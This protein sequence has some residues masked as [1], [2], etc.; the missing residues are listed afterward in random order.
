MMPSV[1][2]LR[3]SALKEC[4]V[5][6]ACLLAAVAAVAAFGWSRA[7]RVPVT[8]DEPHYLIIAASVLRDLDFDVRNNYEQDAATGEIYGPV[9]PHALMR[10]GAPQHMPG[11]G[12]LLAVPFGVGGVVGAR[13]GLALLLVPTLAIVVYRWS[14]N[15]LRPADALL[16][17]LG[18]MACTPVVFGATQIYPDLAGGVAVFALVGW[19][20][21]SDRRTRPAW[22]VYWLVTGLLCWLHVKYYAPSAVLVA[23][24]AWRLWRDDPRYDAATYAVFAVLCLVGPGLFGAFSIPAFGNMLGGREGGELSTDIPRA[25]ELLLGLHL[26]QVH[27]IFL[28]QPFFL[29]GLVALGWMLRRRHPLALPW[30]V[31]YASLIV[32]NAL[33]QI[34]YGG[35]IAPAGRFGWTAMWLWLVPMGVVARSLGG[36]L[37]PYVRVAVLAAIGYQAMHA[38]AWVPEPQRLFN[39][40]FPPQVWQPSLFPAPVM[41]SLPK[42]GPHAGIGYAPNVVW[43]LA[44]LSLLAAGFLRSPKMKYIPA[45]LVAAS[46]PLML[47]VEDDL[48]RSSR[49]VLRRYEA[50]HFCRTAVPASGHRPRARGCPVLNGPW[51]RLDPGAY[52]V[53]VAWYPPFALHDRGTLRVTGGRRQTTI[54]QRDFSLQTGFAAVPFDIE[55]TVYEVE[56]QVTGAPGLEID[57]IDLRSAK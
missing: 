49:A 7:D 45:V 3:A 39:G 4:S 50:E 32:P 46:S 27:G 5:P 29:P 34:T 35:H 57:Y 31:L 56:F 18:A 25:A 43:T 36:A 17:T 47:P 33:Q 44:A 41:L 28:Q 16:A 42:F 52:E 54:V 12:V 53:V 19:L 6:L 37:T 51:I 13:V 21:G 9:T 20:W 23:A 24:G 15:S 55:Q 48:E 40:L 38:L 30:L 1:A 22:C 8:G 2:K 10:V 11:M 26:D 14:R